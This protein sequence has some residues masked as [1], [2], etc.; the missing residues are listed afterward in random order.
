MH[1]PTRRSSKANNKEAL[2]RRLEACLQEPGNQFCADCS[3][4]KPAW[5]SLLL[6]PS[7]ESGKHGKMGVFVCYKCCSYH[8]QLGR[9]VCEVKNIK[10]GDDCKYLERINTCYLSSWWK[11]QDSHNFFAILDVN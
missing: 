2:I 6:V 10:V 3:E 11:L 7:G 8:F 4:T 1:I 9:D 5:A